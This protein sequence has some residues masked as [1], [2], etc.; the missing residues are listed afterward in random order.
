[1]AEPEAAGFITAWPAGQS[2]PNASSV[3]YV[4]GQTVPNFAIVGVGSASQVSLYSLATT[5]LIVDLTGTFSDGGAVPPP[6]G[7]PEFSAAVTYYEPVAS[8]GDSA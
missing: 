7:T 4:A 1:V 3:N 6:P 5:H 8:L 2:R